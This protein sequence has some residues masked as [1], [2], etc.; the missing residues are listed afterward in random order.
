MKVQS[1]LPHKSDQIAWCD[2]WWVLTPPATQRPQITRGGRQL[3]K[4]HLRRFLRTGSIV[5]FI[6]KARTLRT[7]PAPTMAVIPTSRPLMRNLLFLAY[8]IGALVAI[9]AIGFDSHYRAAIWQDAMNRGQ[10]ISSDLERWLRKSL[11]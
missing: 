1:T 9:D 7:R 6:K 3:A 4:R 10:T 5:F 11:W 2:H 8:L